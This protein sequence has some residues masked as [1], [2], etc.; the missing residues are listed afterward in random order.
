MKKNSALMEWT[1]VVDQGQC[2]II[3]CRLGS[4]EAY[5]MRSSIHT[6]LF[7]FSFD[8]KNVFLNEIMDIIKQ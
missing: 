7:S 6:F 8:T 5:I 3:M 1:L 2:K 4:H